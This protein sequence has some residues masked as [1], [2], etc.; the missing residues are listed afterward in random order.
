M[1]EHRIPR[2]AQAPRTWISAGIL[3]ACLAGVVAGLTGGGHAAAATVAAETTVAPAPVPTRVQA[4]D[5]VAP[6]V[7]DLTFTTPAAPKAS[8]AA[9]KVTARSTR[10]R[11]LP[12]V[13]RTTTTPADSTCSG[14]GWEQRR[15]EKALASLLH[16]VPA[17]VTVS[18]LPSRGALKGM[19]YYDQA[20]VD[21]YVQSC[22]SESD[23]LLRHVVAHEMGHAWDGA[24]MTDSLRAEY[25]AARGIKAGTPW[26]GCNGCQ[27]FATPAG[28]FAETY[29]QWQRGVTTSR[30][31]LARPATAAELSS[32]GARFF[33]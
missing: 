9:T 6:Q 15:G 20:H 1:Q 24:H 8:P 13:R 26:F 11:V 28:D 4:V 31:Q 19:T 21:V 30:S 29:A 10:S 16:P 14:A 5:L 33:S 27:D 22:A 3:A 12:V 23:S 18:F 7:V 32:F 2:P 25:L 17:G